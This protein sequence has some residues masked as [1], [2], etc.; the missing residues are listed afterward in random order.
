MS[1]SRSNEV[2]VMGRNTAGPLRAQRKLYTLLRAA[3]SRNPSPALPSLRPL[4]SH[5]CP[6]A[7]ARAARQQRGLACLLFSYR[8]SLMRKTGAF[9]VSHSVLPI[10]WFSWD[11]WGGRGAARSMAAA[12]W[13]DRYSVLAALFVVQAE[14]GSHLYLIAVIVPDKRRLQCGE[15]W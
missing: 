15:W 13:S 9:I 11:G 4:G 14:P 10:L 5:A 6:C 1:S 12:H 7:H 2:E 3:C 8:T